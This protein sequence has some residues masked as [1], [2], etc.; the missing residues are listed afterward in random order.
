[1]KSKIRHFADDGWAVWID[2]DEKSTVYFN[3]WVN[4]EQASYVDIGIRMYG[5]REAKEVNIYIP[6]EVEQ[7]EIN[8]LST[9]LKNKDILRGVF[10]NSCSVSDDLNGN[11]F[12]VTY[13]KHVLNIIKLLPTVY[14]FQNMSSGVLLT[15]DL[16]RI[17]N[18]ITADQLYMIFRLPHKSMD[19]AFKERIDVVSTV[20]NLH[21]IATTPIIT[22]KYGYSTRV[23]E[24]RMMPQEISNIETLHNQNLRKV[25]VSISIN[26]EYEL[27]DFNCYRIRRL[28]E[29]LYNNYA[30]PGFNCLDAVNYQ[31]V[32]ERERN[33]K[34][35]YNFYFDISRNTVSKK[36]LI[37]YLCIVLTLAMMGNTL[38]GLFSSLLEM[39]FG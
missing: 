26:D 13:G 23:N 8:D 2:G 24:A 18:E 16:T 17:K 38:Y 32:E 35:H 30:P 25:L 34:T 4:P 11:V 7:S 10:N 5:A 1:M 31:W 36:S 39:I 15:V 14:Q 29:K 9:M 12:K 20:K 27:N 6:F 19:E 28:E 22:K 3:E 21:E 37:L 33:M